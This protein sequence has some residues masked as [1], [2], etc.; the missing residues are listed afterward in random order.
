MLKG[1][2]TKRSAA[3]KLLTVMSSGFGGGML[4]FWA[5]TTGIGIGDGVQGL[6]A[7]TIITSLSSLS[8]AGCALAFFSG[9]DAHAS[10]VRTAGET[11]ALTGLASRSAFLVEMAKLGAASK[12]SRKVHYFVNIEIDRFKQLNDALGYRTGDQLVQNAAERIKSAMPKTAILGR[13]AIAELG[14]LIPEEDALPTLEIMLD[15]MVG[16]LCEPYMIEGRRVILSV[17]AGGVEVDAEYADVVGVLRKATLAVHRARGRGRGN[18]D[19]FEPEIGRVADHRRWIEAEMQLALERQDFE[20]YYQPQL[21]L[22]TGRIAGYEALVR[23]QHPDKGAVHP[24]EFIP[25][26]EETGMIAPLGDWVLRKACADAKH[27]PD[28]CFVAVNLSPAQFLLSDMVEAVRSALAESG[29]PARRL[30]LEIT[31]SLLME[32]KEKTAL[33]LGEFARMGVSVAVDDFGTGYSN[34]TYLA[35]LPFQKLKIDRSFVS[36]IETNGNTGAIIST[37][38]GLS[39]ALGVETIAEGVENE[40]QVT[41]LKAA[42][43][44]SAQ[45]YLFGRPTPISTRQIHKSATALLH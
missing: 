18:W 11:D 23:W 34:L 43:C 6:A 4:G 15:A 16:S 14:V 5:H 44:N 45:G 32:D 12:E 10:E 35:D 2:K 21:D 33:I 9:I 22:T 42:G 28:D 1:E 8:A 40:A 39:R 31:E 37:I 29:L 13:L 20:L 26:A 19:M 36:R 3:F 7:A 25:V 27:L 41:M 30:E 24:V 17:S 38:V